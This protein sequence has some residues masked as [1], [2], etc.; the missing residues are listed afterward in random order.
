MPGRFTTDRDGLALSIGKNLRKSSFARKVELL[1]GRIG[2][3]WSMVVPA[4]SRG[5]GRSSS[6]ISQPK[7]KEQQYV[8]SRCLINHGTTLPP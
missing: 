4:A 6:L 7:N 8:G 2:F 1:R 5:W 3:D